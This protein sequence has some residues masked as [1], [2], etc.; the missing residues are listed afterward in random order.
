MNVQTNLFLCVVSGDNSRDTEVY[1]DCD[2]Y[3]LLKKVVCS[4]LDTHSIYYPDLSQFE[5]NNSVDFI[6]D[7]DAE[8]YLNILNQIV[9]FFASQDYPLRTKLIKLDQE[10]SEDGILSVSQDV[11]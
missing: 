11:L 4:I 6:S 7:Y 9:C 3:E 8:D 5:V 1:T 10:L 2:Y